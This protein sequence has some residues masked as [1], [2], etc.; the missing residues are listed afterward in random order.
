MFGERCRFFFFRLSCHLRRR[1]GGL[2]A[3]AYGYLDMQGLTNGKYKLTCAQIRCG[4]C[5]DG[6]CPTRPLPETPVIA[7]ESGGTEPCASRTWSTTRWRER[8]FHQPPN[9]RQYEPIRR[10]LYTHTHADTPKTR[11]S[12]RTTC[13]FRPCTSPQMPSQPRRARSSVPRDCPPCFRPS[14]MPYSSPPSWLPRRGRS[15]IVL[16]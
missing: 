14:R 10:L 9:L 1:R 15:C 6:R 16:A 8:M 5:S 3:S 4:S 2:C 12:D 7:G 11:A 13:F